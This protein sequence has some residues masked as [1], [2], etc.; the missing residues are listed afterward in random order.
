MG[1]Y[2][3]PKAQPARPF[4]PHHL[5]LEVIWALF[6]VALVFTLTT[7]VSAPQ[8]PPADPFTTPEHIKPE[9]Y[10]L[11]AYQWLKVC[12][13]LK[14]LGEWAPKTIGVLSQ[15]AAIAVLF[16]A[17]WIDRNKTERSPRK[18]PIAM[19]IFILSILGFVGFTIWGHY[20]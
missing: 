4:W 1:L 16:L 19:A 13:G 7:F 8:E 14:F 11:A 10:F 18:R 2:E 6:M 5:M 12:E 17:P 20:S 3:D 15:G 9:W